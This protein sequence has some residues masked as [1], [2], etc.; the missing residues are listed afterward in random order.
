MFV[1]MIRLGLDSIGYLCEK[2]NNPQ[3]KLRFIHIAGTNG[4][5]STGAYIASI[6]RE[7]GYRVG[8]YTSPAVFRREEIIKVNNRSISAKDYDDGMKLIDNLCSR[9]EAEGHAV[10][11]E[12]E[13]QTALCFNYFVSKACDIVVLECGMGGRTDATNIIENTLVSV[14]TSISL[15][16]TDYLGKTIKE[17]ASVKAG[18]IKKGCAV[19]SAPCDDEVLAE[20][21]KEAQKYG[22]EVTVADVIKFKRGLLPLRGVHQSDNASLAVAAVKKLPAEL[23]RVT[24]K[25]IENGLH[26]TKLNGRFEL[27]KSNPNII[28]DGGHN[29][30][31]AINL[32]ES[33]LSIYPNKRYVFVTGMLKN[34]DHCAYL[35]EILPVACALLTVSTEG[36]RGYSAEDL[37]RDAVCVV[38]EKSVVSSIGG[39]EEAIEIARMMA[40]KQSVIVISG[41][42]TILDKAVKYINGR[43]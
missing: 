6:L 4:K 24:D 1:S 42:F 14:F 9:I 12:F 8:H 23:F 18:I 43:G 31:A 27:I 34:K 32:R 37:A 36:E 41:T 7:A 38:N 19:V 28:I 13:R 3:D 16:H 33:L 20:L 21:S 11:T 39:I 2:L 30:D 5:G 25:N 40:D 17:I 15:D 22:T 35:E 10:P 29:R 26:N